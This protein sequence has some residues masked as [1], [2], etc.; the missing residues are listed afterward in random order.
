MK[1]FSII[2]NTTILA[3]N[4]EEAL[5][6]LFKQIELTTQETLETYLSENIVVKEI[7]SGC[8]MSLNLDE[9]KEDGKCVQCDN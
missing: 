3:D 9:E 8:G 1:N 6:E 5:Q 2:L 4:K 7:C